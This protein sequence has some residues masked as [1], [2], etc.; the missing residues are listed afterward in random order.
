M[1]ISRQTVEYIAHDLFILYEGEGEGGDGG[2]GRGEERLGGKGRG[3]RGEKSYFESASRDGFETFHL[4]DANSK[5]SAQELF[6]LY[7][8]LGWIV[9]FWTVSI[10][11]MSNSWSNTCG[12]KTT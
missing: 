12:Q 7:D 11:N 3:G 4:Y 1:M 8:F 6:I 10:P 9:S 2:R 5:I